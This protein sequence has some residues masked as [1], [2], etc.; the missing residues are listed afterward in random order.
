MYLK[1]DTAINNGIE[2]IQSKQCADG[3]WRDF[4][5]LAGASSDWVSGFVA[6]AISS[7][8]SLDEI[9]LPVI[10]NL[11]RRQR[12]NGGWS[13]NRT[14]PTDCDSTAWVLLALSTSP[15]WRPSAVKRGIRYIEMH[16]NKIFGG[17]ATYCLQ[18]GIHKFIQAPVKAVVDGWVNVHG[19]VTSVAIQSL[20]VHRVPIKSEIIQTSSQYLIRQKNDVGLWDSYWWKGYAY[21]TYHALRALSMCRVLREEEMKKTIQ[22]LLSNQQ[23]D[24][25]WNDNF[26]KTSEVF[27][28]AFIILS[29]LLYPNSETLSASKR[30][31]YW[32]INQ[33]NSD[34]SWPS[35]P[36]L[37]ITPPM[38][39]NPDTIKNWRINQLGT[40]VIIEDQERVF[41]SSA[42]L[43]A[44]MIFRPMIDGI[45]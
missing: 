34:G 9:T 3:L 10:E 19:C 42:A 43:W 2:F 38:V 33:Q 44:L 14:V 24:G 30:G 40:G 7:L 11:M 27:G 16:Q 15:T 21:S 31:I 45:F 39:M 29:L 20:L 32:L 23:G 12:P 4:E 36:I 41:T 17:F 22:F 13:Y 35:A 28:T 1:I 18:D 8:K 6:H 37:K 26:S 25:G 5:T